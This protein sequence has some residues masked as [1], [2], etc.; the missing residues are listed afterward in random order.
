MG[1]KLL[2]KF[3]HHKTTVSVYLLMYPCGY[4]ETFERFQLHYL[5][6][7]EQQFRFLLISSLQDMFINYDKL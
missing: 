6:K 7:K 4:Q 5:R 1:R 3:L 2:N